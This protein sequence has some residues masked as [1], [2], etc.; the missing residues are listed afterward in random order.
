MPRDSWCSEET[1][2]L[3]YMH[4]KHVLGMRFS[5]MLQDDKAVRSK[6]KAQQ[7]GSRHGAAL[8]ACGGVFC[9]SFVIMCGST[10]GV[11]LARTCQAIRI[12]T[13]IQY[14]SMYSRSCCRYVWPTWVP[15]GIEVP[16]DRGARWASGGSCGGLIIFLHLVGGSRVPN[17]VRSGWDQVRVGAG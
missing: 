17:G 6:E 3:T 11:E 14:G 10:S 16:E 15:N 1:A 4:A 2:D 7:H 5:S 9:A 8:P 13:Y 12:C